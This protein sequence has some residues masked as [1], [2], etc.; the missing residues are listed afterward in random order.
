MSNSTRKKKKVFHA[1]QR[2]GELKEIPV[3]PANR[4]LSLVSLAIQ[5]GMSVFAV[6]AVAVR[7]GAAAAGGE[8]YGLGGEASLL[9][10]V[11]PAVSWI[12][13]LGFRL[14]CLYLPLE[15]WRLPVRVRC[16]FERTNGTLLKLMTLLLELETALCFFYIDVSLYAGYVPSDA[17]MLAWVAALALS[18]YLPGRRA[19]QIADRR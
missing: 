2:K 5:A 9:Y 7:H 16:G 15:M 6:Y 19:A 12:L 1:P 17:V 14:A 13:T 11:F 18:V 8:A 4:I 3:T 10:L